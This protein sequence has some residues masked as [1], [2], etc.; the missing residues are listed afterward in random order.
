MSD[1]PRTDA[2]QNDPVLF[3]KSAI[4]KGLVLLQH[5]RQLERE[6]AASQARVKMLEK[7]VEI[8]S[9]Y[10]TCARCEHYD[11]KMEE[12]KD[13]NIECNYTPKVMFR[14]AD[15]D[16]GCGHCER[17]EPHTHPDEQPGDEC[18]R[19]K[20]RVTCERVTQ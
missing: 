2:I 5:S 18:Y 19:R 12:C 1:T 3:P 4:E 9:N 20:G 7:Q 6:L 10:R 14:C 17:S 8:V 16:D 13:N 11:A 15:R